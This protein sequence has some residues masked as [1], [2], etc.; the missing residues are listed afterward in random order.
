[1]DSL[2]SQGKNPE[3]FPENSGKLRE[4]LREKTVRFQ[5]LFP[6]NSDR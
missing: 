3:K 6:E 2:R 4:I 5:G 1:M